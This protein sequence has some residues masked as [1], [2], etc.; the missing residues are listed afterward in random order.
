MPQKN[1]YI[2]FV[3]AFT[4]NEGEPGLFLEYGVLRWD[5]VPSTRPEVFVHSYLRPT[6]ANSRIRWAVASVEMKITREF[7]DGKGELPTMEDMIEADYLNNKSV[8]CFDLRQDPFPDLTSNCSCT[9]IVDMWQNIY[10]DD[11]KALSCF[12]LNQMCDYIRLLPDDKVNTNYTPLLKRLH[13]MAALWSFLSEIKKHP[14]RRKT[15]SSGG[16]QFNCIWPLPK[17]EDEW[18]ENEPQSFEDLTDQQID[19]F[20]NGNLSDRL[21]WFDISMYAYD[22]IYNRPK[23]QG[24]SDLKGQNELTSFIFNKILSFKVKILVLIFFSVFLHRKE[25][26]LSIAKKHGS[27][28]S[29]TPAENERFSN[30]IVSN[31]DVFLTQDQQ[32]SL[33]ASLINQSLDANDKVPFTH[34]DYD[35]LQKRAKEDDDGPRYIF[36]SNAPDNKS[37]SCYKEIR[38]A[39]GKTIYRCYEVKGRG[40]DRELNIDLVNRN[41]NALLKDA[42]NPFSSFWLTSELKLWIQYISGVSF[43]EIERTVKFND[44]EKLIATRTILKKIVQKEATPYLKALYDKLNQCASSIQ[45]VTNEPMTIGFNFQG[46]SLEVIITPPS[47]MSFLRKIFDFN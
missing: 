36:T 22:W 15:L 29:L 17:I 20:F 11:E 4:P 8:V 30:F 2:Y 12:D 24:L 14:K 40:K 46:I 16:M 41:L 5:S 47:K 39:S 42:T 35:S 28:G 26:A 31:L 37:A 34:Y 32:A 44:S 38:E 43:T 33:I 45:E 1:Q 3:D 7:L 21:N 27:L 19:D 25:I 9:S 6:G 10:S 18:F 23:S 13:Q